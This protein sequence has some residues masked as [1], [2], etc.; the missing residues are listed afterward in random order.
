MKTTIDNNMRKFIVQ[1]QGWS[2]QSI[3]CNLED[4]PLAMQEM[5]ATDPYIILEYWNNRLK[6]CSKKHLNDMFAANGIN[7]KVN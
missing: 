5:K 4:L 7:F 1:A 3:V 6:R 2:S